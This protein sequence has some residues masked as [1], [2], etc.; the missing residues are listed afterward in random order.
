MILQLLKGDMCETSLPSPSQ[1]EK[2]AQFSSKSLAKAPA[3][4]KS[5]GRI[6]MSWFSV[7]L[8]A[9]PAVAPAV[10][11]SDSCDESAFIGKHLTT[12]PPYL[13]L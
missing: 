3:K 5:K 13:P 2:A 7:L 8:P 4:A 11:R 1:E 12:L 6:Q 10:H 9:P